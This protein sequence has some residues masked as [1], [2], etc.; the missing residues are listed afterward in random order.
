MNRFPYLILFVSMLFNLSSFAQN[1]QVDRVEP[2]FWWAGMKSEQLQLLIYGENIS[3]TEPVIEYPGIKVEKVHRVSSPNYLFIDL[4]I[5]GLSEGADIPIK[6]MLDGRRI[7]VHEYS[8]YERRPGSAERKGFSPEDVIYLLMPDRFA[9]AEPANDNMPGMLEEAERRNPNGRHGGDIH[10]IIDNLDYIKDL[11]MTTI[12]P[13]PVLENNMPE[14]S[15]H[16]YAITDFYKVDPRLGT[17]EDY[18]RLVREC[19]ER[20][21][22]VIMDMV[23]NHCG[24]GHW[25]IKDLPDQD[26]INQWPEFTRS[27]YR[28][29]VLPDPYSSQYDFERMQKG[30][31]DST[32]ADMNQ[33]HPHLAKYLV[34][35]SIWWVEYADLDGIRMDT[36]PYAFQDFMADWTKYVLSEYPNFNIVGECWLQKESLT[37]YFDG[38]PEERLG[39]NTY[40]PSITDFPM[41]FAMDRALNRKTTWTEGLSAWYYVLT[42]DIVYHNPYYNVI[43]LDNHDITRFYTTIGEDLDKYKMGIAFLFTT[44]G[45]PMIYYGTEILMTGNEHDGHGYIRKDFPGGWE[46]DTVDAFNN[47]G[48]NEDQQEAFEYTRKLADFRKESRALQYGKLTQFIPQDTTYVYFREHEEEAVMIIMSQNSQDKTIDTKRYN[49]CLQSFSRGRSVITGKELDALDELTIPAM[50]VEIIELKK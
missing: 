37:G 7:F 33:H 27:N 20:G 34:Q 24:T 38:D 16:G 41:M 5:G 9:N 6:F 40:L 15:Y 30:W 10:G 14:F 13:N 23:F 21:L 4:N 22:K 50:G 36:Y 43:F 11:G 47:Q 25:W 48:L 26:W 12:W 44:R 3:M 18:I 8:F 46:T 1:P 35:N 39:P 45:I 28:N 2:P 49:E 31:F 42:Q 19:H 29:P 17:N 32:M